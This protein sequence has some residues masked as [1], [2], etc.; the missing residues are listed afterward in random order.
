MTPAMRSGGTFWTMLFSA[1]TTTTTPASTRPAIC[2]AARWLGTRA[3]TTITQ[4][5]SV[6][7]SRTERPNSSAIVTGSRTRAIRAAPKRWDAAT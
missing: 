4:E 3:D 2:C 7:M 6:R 5:P 1:V